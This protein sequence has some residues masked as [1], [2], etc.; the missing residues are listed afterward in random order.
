LNH[1]LA[2]TFDGELNAMQL[3]KLLA[4]QSRPEVP[5]VRANEVNAPPSPP[6][7]NVW[8]GGALDGS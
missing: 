1:H 2:R 5:V 6:S 7:D 8:S 3:G 4:S